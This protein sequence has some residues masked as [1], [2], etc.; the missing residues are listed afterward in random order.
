M[1]KIIIAFLEVFAELFAAKSE[2]TGLTDKVEKNGDVCFTLQE[3]T[4]ECKD[5]T[6]FLVYAA[7]VCNG[8]KKCFCSDNCKVSSNAF[9]VAKDVYKVVKGKLIQNKL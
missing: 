6:Y 5:F 1:R 9:S 8:E 3:C 7:A 2:C 4:Q